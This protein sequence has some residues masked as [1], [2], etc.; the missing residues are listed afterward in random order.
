MIQDLGKLAFLQTA[1]DK[2]SQRVKGEMQ[3]YKGRETCLIQS[4]VLPGTVQEVME[5]TV[6]EV[7][8]TVHD[9]LGLCF[10]PT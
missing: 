3:I 6:K 9:A 10:Y 7:M 5:E 4:T 1:V 2:V 8:E